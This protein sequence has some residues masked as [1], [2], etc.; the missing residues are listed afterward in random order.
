MRCPTLLLFMFTFSKE[1]KAFL[2]KT[3]VPLMEIWSNWGNEAVDII[4]G[5]S[6]GEPGTQVTLQTFHTDMSGRIE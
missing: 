4:A 2:G 1:K 5:Q 3:G 6:I